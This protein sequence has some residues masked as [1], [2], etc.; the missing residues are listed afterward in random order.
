V[1]AHP[2]TGRTDPTVCDSLRGS[3][4]PAAMAAS[5]APTPQAYLAELDEAT[6]AELATVAAVVRAAVP[7]GFEEG[8]DYGMITWSV[9]LSLYPDTPNRHPLTYAG[10]AAHKRYN[11]LYLSAA[12]DCAGGRL[13]AQAMRRHWSGRKPLDMGKSCVRFRH[14]ADLDLALIAQVLRQWTV[15][16]FVAF[17]KAQRRS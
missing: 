15:A 12:C 8:M 1:P 10:L 14:A 17:A 4:Y 13:D 9:P 3:A 16:D 7:A 11:S 5:A 2:P 6:R